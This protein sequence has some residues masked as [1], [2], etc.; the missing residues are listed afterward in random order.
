MAKKSGLTRYFA[1]SRFI[2]S[3]YPE[4]ECL[5]YSPYYTSKEEYYGMLRFHKNKRR[6]LKTYKRWRKKK[7][8]T[9]I[10]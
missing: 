1:R 7:L 4:T 2:A 10:T 9:T 8:N 6:W 5:A 3:L